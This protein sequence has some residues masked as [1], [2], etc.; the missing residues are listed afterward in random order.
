MQDLNKRIL[1]CVLTSDLSCAPCSFEHRWFF[2]ASEWRAWLLHY[3][4]VVLKGI[5]TR[6]NYKHW[7]LLVYAMNILPSD[8]LTEPILSNVES[9]LINF[10]IQ[11]ENLYGPQNMSYNVHQ[12]LHIVD[13]VRNWGPLWYNSAFP[14]ESMNGKL[15]KLF[16]GTQ[17]RG[18]Q[19][20][21][22]ALYPHHFKK[23]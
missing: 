4:P 1:T 20:L 23:I 21:D 22:N 5:Q 7:L 9:L 10:V 13:S 11:Y 8:Q 2:K 15:L 16:H 17:F 14:F 6:K 18:I 19:I 3:S 12:L